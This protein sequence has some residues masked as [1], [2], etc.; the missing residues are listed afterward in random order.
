[1]KH[2]FL[3]VAALRE[4]SKGRF[5]ALRQPMLY[6]G[7]GKINATM[8]LMGYLSTLDLKKRPKAIINLGTAGSFIFPFGQIYQ[9]K[10]FFQ[11]DMLCEPLAKKYCTPFD[12]RGGYI[13]MKYFTERYQAVDCGSGDHFVR[14]A[15]EFSLF[16]MEGYALAKVCERFV[17]PFISLKCISDSGLT[18]DWN[19][20]LEVC[21]EK[22]AKAGKGLIQDLR[23]MF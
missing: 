1:M 23:K 7:V 4:E 21:S 16:D 13:D 20:N 6:T 2:D 22:L 9:V 8:S 18:A 15:S 19:A 5:E 17:I 14:S 10:I 12:P 3:I 11:S